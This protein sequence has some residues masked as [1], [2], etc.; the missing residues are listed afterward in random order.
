MQ[1]PEVP[2]PPN[3]RRYSWPLSTTTHDAKTPSPEKGNGVFTD[4]Q[5]QLLD[6]KCAQASQ[7]VP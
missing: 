4:D 7:G 2:P 1:S 6:W 5:Y 3:L